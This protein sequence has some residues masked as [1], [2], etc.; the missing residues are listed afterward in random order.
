MWNHVKHLESQLEILAAS[1]VPGAAAERYNSELSKT[2]SHLANNPDTSGMSSS[3]L[4][5]QHDVSMNAGENGDDD[6]QLW[7]AWDMRL[8][9]GKAVGAWFGGDDADAASDSESAGGS[10]SS[11][12]VGPAPLDLGADASKSSGAALPYED[13][14]ELNKRLSVIDALD[15]LVQGLTSSRSR[16]QSDLSRLQASTDRARANPVNANSTAFKESVA[17]KLNALNSS[18]LKRTDATLHDVVSTADIWG[19]HASMAAQLEEMS[20][21]LTEFGERLRNEMDARAQLTHQASDLAQRLGDEQNKTLVLENSGEK[22][23]ATRLQLEQQVSLLSDELS[24]AKN[25]TLAL[26]NKLSDIEASLH[27]EKKSSAA[28]S[29][30]LTAAR[31]ETRDVSLSL[32]RLTKQLASEKQLRDKVARQAADLQIELTRALESAELERNTV[33]DLKSELADAKATIRSQ[34][35][36]SDVSAEKLN[37]KLIE[38]TEL[39]LKVDE[40]LALNS[41]L[42]SRLIEDEAQK[43]FL[44]SQ[45]LL[46]AENVEAVRRTHAA[47]LSAANAK[48]DSLTAEN[49]SLADQVDMLFA[50]L[51]EL[52]NREETD[53]TI[54]ELRRMLAEA[55]SAKKDMDGLVVSLR[56]ELA[57]AEDALA[58]TKLAHESELALAKSSSASAVSQAK[59]TASEV[60]AL[61][62][63]IDELKNAL[64]MENKKRVQLN[65]TIDHQRSQI[66][67]LKKI[68]AVM[69]AEKDVLR[70]ELTE[71][72][73]DLEK[74][75]HAHACKREELAKMERER[76]DWIAKHA[77]EHT[78][79]LDALR[80]RDAALADKSETDKLVSE[81]SVAQ[82]SV[83]HTSDDYKRQLESMT[84]ERDSLLAAREDVLTELAAHQAQYDELAA[85]RVSLESALNDAKRDLGLA[86]YQTAELTK[87]LED[88]K[89]EANGAN[90]RLEQVRASKAALEAQIAHTRNKLEVEAAEKSQATVHSVTLERNI[91]KLQEDLAETKAYL[92]A[93]EKKTFKLQQELDST[94][95]SL[96]LKTKAYDEVKVNFDSVLRENQDLVSEARGLEDELSLLRRKLQTDVA[97]KDALARACET[98]DAEI[99]RYRAD[100]EDLTAQKYAVEQE[101]AKANA[102]ISAS[103]RDKATFELE[104]MSVAQQLADA[105]KRLE[106]KA[107]ELDETLAAWRAEKDRYEARIVDLEAKQSQALAN[108]QKS[109]DAAYDQMESMTS[110]TQLKYSDLEDEIN[111]YKKQLH[112]ALV[113][114]ESLVA[115]SAA[116]KQT[117]DS[118]T[119][120]AAAAAARQDKADEELRH[121]QLKLTK[122]VTSRDNALSRVA[123]LEDDLRELTRSNNALTSAHDALVLSEAALRERVEAVEAEL[124]EKKRT[125]RVSKEEVAQLENDA[126]TAA[127][128]IARLSAKLESDKYAAEQAAASLA[129]AR[130]TSATLAKEKDSLKLAADAAL[131]EVDGY[132]D[133]CKDLLQSISDLTVERDA[134]KD[135]LAQVSSA[136]SALLDSS[137]ATEARVETSAADA[138]DLKQRLDR[139]KDANM[140]LQTELGEARVRHSELSSKILEME[141]AMGD[142]RREAALAQQDV[143][144]ANEKT[145]RVEAKLEAA[146]EARAEAR[147]ELEKVREE[148]RYLQLEHNQ[149]ARELK[150]AQSQIAELQAAVESEKRATV[151][152]RADEDAAKQR[153][154]AKIAE[155]ESQI[156]AEADKVAAFNAETQRAVAAEARV[157]ELDAEVAE[158]DAAVRA[159]RNELQACELGKSRAE[160]QAAESATALEREIARRTAAEVQV[161]ELT[162]AAEE[163]GARSSTSTAN[164]N[165]RIREAGLAAADAERALA[166]EKLARTSESQ[167]AS[168]RES[169]LNAQIESLS[170]LLDSEREQRAELN[171][172]LVAEREK[173]VAAEAQIKSLTRQ[174]EDASD[175]VESLQA[176]LE[177]AQQVQETIKDAS[178]A[179][180]SQLEGMLSDATHSVEAAQREIATTKA[181]LDASRQEAA[182][183]A[184]RSQLLEEELAEAS[185]ASNAALQSSTSV[186][187][188]ALAAARENMNELATKLNE[189]NKAR[190]EAQ[191]KIELLEAECEALKDEVD[192]VHETSAEASTVAEAEAGD[193][194]A[195]V[196]ELQ[197]KL[198]EAQRAME[199]KDA[200]YAALEDKAAEAA[201]MAEMTQNQL[202]SKIES[203]HTSV[204]SSESQVASLQQTLEKEAKLE[205]DLQSKIIAL[206]GAD[207]KLRAVQS[208]LEEVTLAH[209]TLKDRFAATKDALRAAEAEANALRAASTTDADEVLAMK[210]KLRET[211][212]ALQAAVNA[213]NVAI[214]ATAPGA[215]AGAGTGVEAKVDALVAENARLAGEVTSLREHVQQL[216]SKNRELSVANNTLR[217]AGPVAAA[218]QAAHDDM[219]TSELKELHARATAAEAELH[220]LRA[221]LLD[222]KSRASVVKDESATLRAQVAREQARADK[223]EAQV[224]ALERK[225]LNRSGS[226]GSLKGER[227]SSD[228]ETIRSL[229]KRIVQLQRRLESTD[230][231]SGSAPAGGESS[232]SE[233]SRNA[234]K[235]KAE[236]RAVRTERDEAEMQIRE[237]KVKVSKLSRQLQAASKDREKLKVAH[238]EEIARLKE[239]EVIMMMMAQNEDL[240]RTTEVAKA[241]AAKLRKQRKVDTNRIHELEHQ[242]SSLKKDKDTLMAFQTESLIALEHD[243]DE[244]RALKTRVVTL[245]RQL[246]AA[247]ASEDSAAT[248]QRRRPRQAA[249]LSAVDDSDD[250]GTL[251]ALDAE[252]EASTQEIDAMAERMRL[253]AGDSSRRIETSDEFAF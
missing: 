184:A 5:P 170:A 111:H 102:S 154:A 138:S 162:K 68:N 171:E 142:V 118:A 88:A 27:A 12:A 50:E 48:I 73:Q 248:P 242:L 250:D 126:K 21:Q 15:Q 230:G 11:N 49:S 231:G 96:K 82:S 85:I 224:K 92:D 163:A 107:A 217:A 52:Q 13:V 192:N 182:T 234:A 121:T 8:N 209:G 207:A 2:V 198:L 169:G 143:M 16:W 24:A 100:V 237:L 38:V 7:S 229:K 221:T 212:D 178:F 28:L 64:H 122:A 54:A 239:G 204:G 132:K 3:M 140:R 35:A 240:S 125:L 137:R 23:S 172:A 159:A 4:Q 181:A 141:R 174:L 225:M 130:A 43:D 40:L 202:W 189:A 226:M 36:E 103:G 191:A 147:A 18:F 72:E 236:L 214:E 53:M 26:K 151:S 222:T 216:R 211:E 197:A 78:L 149:T 241:E 22:E 99:A 179:Q 206:E 128:E 120:D 123:N 25:N 91:A 62:E 105:N 195:Q 31:D 186:H 175:E 67:D 6:R 228:A 133:K 114:E 129:D 219:M 218:E 93:E 76:D 51:D 104:K 233:A 213:V 101:L 110:Q 113:R 124:L 157:A 148:K 10:A 84:R 116:L 69:E 187:Q 245:E 55:L 200:E 75:I 183:L 155:L 74:E 144:D 188:G 161:L 205:R 29:S 87:K 79:L 223:A 194:A 167:A 150:F 83:A 232:G 136:H 210:A 57:A 235:Y 34:T 153:A 14:L 208:E 44:D 94:A 227:S 41:E 177:A 201:K 77:H 98:K 70:T 244:V 243:T 90:Q 160:K 131:A 46:L 166:S 33:S 61:K 65:G 30:E 156:S 127:L 115:E 190:R 112:A 249:P 215:A 119:G 66:E 9:I 42:E 39:R 145:S 71:F 238:K 17:L 19:E 117:A 134:L 108:L 199:E 246:A 196:Q 89:R 58:D 80:A 203:L 47:E 1:H 180:I 60:S 165:R 176:D 37:D 193:L 152:A 185:S 168:E 106:L 252:I 135:Q 81:L 109:L 20:A 59:S 251:A 164:L 32:D 253:R 95:E 56:T 97:E 173:A 45:K 146:R 63:T 220:G 158:L 86:H 247:Q 139:T